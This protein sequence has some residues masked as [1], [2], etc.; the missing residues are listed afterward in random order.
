MASE[1]QGPY[2]VYR[3]YAIGRQEAKLRVSGDLKDFAQQVLKH[4]LALPTGI[5]A[6]AISVDPTVI[7]FDREIVLTVK[8]E[9]EEG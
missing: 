3:V 1:V 7:P 8:R 6:D 5:T 4:F 2:R 9:S